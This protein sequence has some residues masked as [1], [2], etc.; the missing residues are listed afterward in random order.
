[1]IRVLYIAGYGRSGS[2]LLDIVLA[3]HEN[4][5]GLGEVA[6][7]PEEIAL[8]ERTC[9]CGSRYRSCSFWGDWTE[10]IGDPR[11]LREVLLAIEQRRQLPALLLDRQ[12]QDL[13]N[14][15]TRYHNELLRYIVER[16]GAEILVDSS[17]NGRWTA[18]RFLSLE[19]LA[20]V[21]VH[22]LHLIR[23]GAATVKS[24][25]EHGSNW[26]LEGKRKPPAIPGIRASVGWTLANGVAALLR[27]FLPSERYCRIWYRD[28]VES[29][30]RVLTDIGVWLDVDME[31]VITKIEQD[32]AFS[33][34]HQVG[35]NRLRKQ[36]RVRVRTSELSAVPARHRITFGLIGAWLELLLRLEPS[37]AG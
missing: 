25:A 21:E 23:R 5:F 18:G 8:Q 36:G 14:R 17:K 32:Q 4:I 27:R 37:A 33:V 2:T 13:R 3:G 22:V 16:S 6:C 30:R 29:P 28:L 26:A 20:D 24:Y 12:A 9:A 34:G 1:M 11:G 15:Y 19:R 7:L 35:G 31:E 10:R